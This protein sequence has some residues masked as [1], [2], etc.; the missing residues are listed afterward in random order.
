[1][2]QVLVLMLGLRSRAGRQWGTSSRLVDIRGQGTVIAYRTVAGGAKG[3]AGALEGGAGIC[4]EDARKKDALGS[5]NRIAAQGPGNIGELK[6]VR[7]GWNAESKPGSVRRPGCTHIQSMW[8]GLG[9]DVRAISAPGGSGAR[10]EM[11]VLGTD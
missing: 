6:I 9:A 7:G 8:G 11:F 3:E 2:Y 1:M 10:S 4:Q 5:R